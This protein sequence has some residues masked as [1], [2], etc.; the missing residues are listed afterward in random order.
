MLERLALLK[1]VMEMVTWR[2]KS[3]PR[4]GGDISI[5]RELD[6]WYEQCLQCGYQRA[7]SST[8]EVY[9]RSGD[10]EKKELAGLQVNTLQR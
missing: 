8:G 3:C 2:L 9:R 6:G 5:D 1:W 7:I 10:K 4:C